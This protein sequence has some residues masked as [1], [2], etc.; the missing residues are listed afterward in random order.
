MTIQVEIKNI[1]G[2]E[3][4][5]PVCEHAKLLA[6]LAGHKTLTSYDVQVIKQL[7]YTVEVVSAHK[8]TL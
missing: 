2:N 8:G 1:Y 3:T 6:K 4:V 7:G 5:Y